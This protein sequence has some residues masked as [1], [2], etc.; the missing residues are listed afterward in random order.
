MKIKKNLPIAVIDSG[1]GGISVLRELCALMPTESFIYFGDSKNAP[2]GTKSREE[3]L[4]ITRENLEFLKQRGIKALVVACN[5]ATSAAVRVLRE[6]ES[7]L[8]IVGIEPAVKPPSVDLDH[9]TVLCMATPLTLKEEKFKRLCARFSDVED[10]IPLPC[11]RLV[12]FIE[13]GELDTGEL[14]EYLEELLSPYR[15]VKI[16]ALVLGCTHYPHVKDAIAQH[17]SPTVKIYDGGAGTARE[18]LR[19]LREADLV[20]DRDGQGEI[21]ILNSS[22]DEGMIELSRRLLYR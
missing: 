9:P 15:D 18:T 22:G 5:T 11:P 3:V 10:I 17:V 19:R 2:Y 4:K 8:V 13:R 1:V 12:E 7:E 16:D 20:G 6:E 21:E 14:H